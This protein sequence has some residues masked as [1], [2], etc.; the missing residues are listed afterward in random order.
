MQ[1]TGG[2]RRARANSRLD[3][4]TWRT[5]NG[6]TAS[7]T[8][9]TTKACPRFRAWEIESDEALF[10]RARTVDEVIGIYR[11]I[12]LVRANDEKIFDA[13]QDGG[14]V[15]ALLIWGLENG[16]IEGALTSK[17][18]EERV[19]DAEPCVVT[20]RE[21]VLASAGSRYTYAANPL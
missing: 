2:S 11:D 15:S 17:L 18:S 14:L 20:N 5:R 10:G 9:C 21:E 13:G 19:W 6:R 4:G 1:A 8:S 16:K 12:Y 7:G 3:C